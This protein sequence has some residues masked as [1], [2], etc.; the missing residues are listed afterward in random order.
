M[1]ADLDMLKEKALQWGA[2]TVFSGQQAADA[3]LQLLTTGM[4]V[5]ESITTMQAVLTGAAAS[6][7][8]LGT[9]ADKLTNIMA[10]MGLETSLSTDIIDKLAR[11]SGVV[12]GDMASLMDAMESGAGA[13]RT[14]GIEY[15]E[16]IPMLGIWSDAGIRGSEA[17]TA[18]RSMLMNMTSDTERTQGA[19]RRLNTTMFD[20]QG[21]MRPMDA[22]LNDIRTGLATMTEEEQ[23]RTLTDLAG[24]YGITGLSAL[25]ASEGIDDMN[26]RMSQ[27]AS[28]SDV[29]EAQMGTFDKTIESLK[30]SVEALQITALTPLME[31]VLQPLAEDLI[32][33][34][35]SI[36]MWAAENPE[37]TST[38]LKI[39]G[40]LV[41]AGPLL[42]GLGFAIM[43]IGAVIG[44]ILSPIGLLIA[45]VAA[46]AAAF[47]T[48]F[49]GIRTF[50][51]NTIIP[52]FGGLWDAIK[53]GGLSGGLNFIKEQ[54][55]DPLV[56]QVQEFIDSGALWEALNDLGE[57]ILRAVAAG[58]ELAIPVATWLFDN[59]I[60]PL[61]ESVLEYTNS[62]QL[63]E[64]LKTLGEMFL[65]A[66]AAGLE[67]AIPIATW[68]FD[69]LIMP[70]GAAVLEYV[71][72][73]K[74]WDDLKSLAGT[75]LPALGD[76]LGDVAGW[77]KTNVID[78]IVEGLAGLAQLVRTAINNAIPDSISF[79][80]PG[81]SLP[82]VGQ[83]IGDTPI[84]INLPNDPIPAFALGTSYVQNTGLAQLHEGEGDV[85]AGGMF[86]RPSPGGLLLEGGGG[87]GGMTIQQVVIHANSRAEGAAAA[88]AFEERLQM[89]YDE[90]GR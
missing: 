75:I 65:R 45:G 61:A 51:E 48:D 77:I 36:R 31:D 73:G 85:P 12:A 89:L 1:G 21:A 26:M 70:L 32:E 79:T 37:L 34:V 71:G 82:V 18:L 81:V 72:S 78:K 9:T 42:V 25:L 38:I 30:G 7:A 41:I 2:D 66:L 88:D 55:I 46:L 10:G 24:A 19:W 54:L 60:V 4:S 13:A 29:A 53:E 76:G 80:I 11:A 68:L 40:A 52:F 5:N 23:A 56:A 16:L 90:R 57:M 44:L 17:G 87:G 33:V 28:A 67:L 69:N 83:V 62:G 43:G 64:D 59:L 35:N 15:D 74:L 20:A 58:L 86:V 3:F 8:D 39:A 6:G 22:I 14:F 49:G 27:A 47:I 84:R 63:W 50:F